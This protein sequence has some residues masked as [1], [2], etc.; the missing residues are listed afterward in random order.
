MISSLAGYA[1]LAA[2]ALMIEVLVP[3]GTLMLLMLLLAGRSSPALMRRLHAL[4]PFQR[5]DPRPAH[6]A[7]LMASYAM[8]RFE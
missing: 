2:K 5:K 7:D 1:K 6:G 3:G 8:R 4:V